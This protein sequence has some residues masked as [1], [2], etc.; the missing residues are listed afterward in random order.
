M[1]L[2]TLDG[3]LDLL[4]RLA[5]DG[6]ITPEF[7]E[8][9]RGHGRTPEGEQIKQDDLKTFRNPDWTEGDE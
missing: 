3:M 6:H 7:A 9:M 8:A 1:K 4:D 2:A 5:R